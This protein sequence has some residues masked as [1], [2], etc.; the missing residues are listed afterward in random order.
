MEQFWLAQAARVERAA[1]VMEPI[2]GGMEVEQ[3]V[4]LGMA[5]MAGNGQGLEM[6]PEL[7]ALVEQLVE[8]MIPVTVAGMNAAELVF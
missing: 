1:L 3:A 2:D 7:Q 8:P 4:I 5:A 6:L